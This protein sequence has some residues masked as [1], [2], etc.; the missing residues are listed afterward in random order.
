MRLAPRIAT[1][2]LLATALGRPVAGAPGDPPTPPGDP[3]PPIPIFLNAPTDLDAFW[4]MLARPDFVVLDGDLYRKLRLASEAPKL[5]KTTP[6]AVVES[7]EVSGAVSGD[8]A[9]L[10]VEIRVAMVTDGPSW[11]PIHLDGLTLWDVRD[12]SGDLPTRIAEGR[13]WQVELKGRGEH[14][15]RVGLLAPV[16][17]TVEGKRLELPVPPASSTR[18]DLVVPQNVLDASTGS[19]EPVGMTP[20]PDHQG[21]RLTARLSPRPRLDLAWRERA[22]PSSQLPT[23]LS[24]Q[25][26]ISLEIERGSIRSRSSWVLASIRGTTSVLT[27]RLDSAEELLDIEVDNKPVQVE[28]RREGGRSVVSIPLLDPLR[29]NAMRTL[30][31]N[32]RRPI[33]SSGIARVALQ[34]YSFDQAKVQTGV[35]AIARTGPIFLNPTPGRV[36]RRID[37]RT[38]L[39]ENLRARPD[40]TLAFEF[41]DQ[42]FDLALE[43]EPAPPR[44]RVG[45]RTTVTVDPRSARLQTR[46]DCRTSQGR[47]FEVKVDLPKG[48]EFEG[49]EPASVVESAQVLPIDP[50]GAPTTGV[51]VPRVVTLT[52]TPQAR[53]SDAFTI[54]LKGWCA[55]DPSGPVALPIFQPRVDSNEGARYAIVADRNVSVE[56]ATAGEEPPAFRV[57]WG[58]PPTDWPWPSRRPGAELGLLWLRCDANP[59]A[60]PVK[61][62]VHPRSIRHESTLA[63][64]IDRRGAEVVEEISVDVAFGVASRLDISLPPEVP[65]RWEVEGIELAAREPLGPETGG[66]RRY[67]LRF[68]R[69]YTDA[70]RLR[71]RY[72]L[73]FAEP[74]EGEREAKLRLEPI[75]VLEGNS[76]AHRV[77]VS[78]EPRFGLKSDAKG[79]DMATIS[80]SIPSTEGGPPVRLAFSNVEERPGPVDLLVRAGP[81][82]PLPGVVVSRLWIRTVQRPEN[83]LA[84]SA[85]FWVEARDGSMRVG[86]PP[87]S[88]WVRARVGGSDLSEGNVEHLA[89]DEYRLR[90]PGPTP[91]GPV[92]VAI[93]FVVPAASTSGGWPTL[94]LLGGGIVQ[95]TTW[96]VQ[97]LGSRAGV[98]TPSGWTDENEWFWA[99]GLWK[100]RPWK[101]PLEVSHW[102]TGGNAR[103][104]LTEMLDSGVSTGLQSYLFSRVGPPTTLR[105]PIFSRIGLLLLCSGPVLAVGLL[106]L[107][108]RPPPRVIAAALLILAFAAGSLVEPN[109]LILALQ[110]S[111]L[112]VAL[113]LSALAMNW[114]I[115]KTTHSRGA[116]E[117]ALIVAS[118]STASSML[119]PSPTPGS[120]E[121]TEIRARPANPAA[122]STADHVVLIRAPG[123]LPDEF[124]QPEPDHR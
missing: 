99:G 12:G 69:D 19:N 109:V 7:L 43:V 64:A 105:F 103:Y 10:V 1:F 92:L 29:P 33:A 77:V 122:V 68:A 72:R 47:V 59:E 41:H 38:E 6:T 87:G 65:D 14:V 107:A 83:D 50:E 5:V 30:L 91:S 44:L 32:T 36:L 117:G 108:R 66:T 18:L 100:R 81:Q 115:E 31:L 8:W 80:D 39:P 48:L 112:G 93:D 75:R 120:D 104:R 74:P 73:H 51:D 49:A 61:V 40:T 27:L 124:S 106:V 123:S 79:W 94:R 101:S 22:D 21:V 54:L 17:S 119:R 45:A 90:F 102:L 55:I 34:G 114:A 116:G 9:R 76:T 26:E 25:G 84:T 85:R 88:R 23:L 98:G 67:R 52:L 24:A 4:K 11:V 89:A 95:Q 121:S 60:I 42:P 118:S 37:P 13:G 63:A 16:R 15:V 82:I 28:T 35:V 86:L 53:E 78:A 70:F 96:E 58:S 57:D 62:A 20:V 2:V 113:W 71:V 111:L 3:D 97:V 56:L 110:S 46:L